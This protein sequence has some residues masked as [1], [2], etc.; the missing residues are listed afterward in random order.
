[1][2]QMFLRLII[3]KKQYHHHK[4]DTLRIFDYVFLINDNEIYEMNKFSLK[5]RIFLYIRTS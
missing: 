3:C 2:Y 1:M 5:K 4:L